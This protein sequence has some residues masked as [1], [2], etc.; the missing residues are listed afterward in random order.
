MDPVVA[1]PLFGTFLHAFGAIAAALCYTPQQGLRGWS[2]QTYWLT[3]ASICWLIAPIVGAFLTVPHLLDVLQAAPREAMLLTFALGVVYGVGGTAFGMAI[4]YV[5]YSLTYAIAIGISCFVGTFTG[6]LLSGTL[7]GIV[8]KAGSSWVLTG[9]FIGV[10]GTLA[11]G[12]AGRL[13]EIEIQRDQDNT[14]SFSLG[15]GLLLC[16]IAGLLSA[17]YGIAI[18]DAGKPIAEAAARLGAGHWQTN[19]VYIFVNSG[20]FLTTAVYTLFLGRRQK[21]LSEFTRLNALPSR[22]LLVNYLLAILTGCLWYGQFLFYGLGHVRMGEFKFSSWAIHMTMLILFSSLAGLVL[23]EWHGRRLRTKLALLTALSLLVTAVLTLTYGNLLG[24]RAAASTNPPEPIKAFCVDFNWG[25]GGPNG[26]AAP[27]VFNQADPAE[28]VA[29]YQD[30]GCNTIQTFCVSCC[31]YAWYRSDIAPVQPDMKGDFLKE[32]TELAHQ[33]DMKVMGYFCVGA[34]THWAQQH[35]DMSY[36]APS[37][38]HLPLTTQYLDYLCSCIEE[39]L[40]KT[41][42]DGFMID[43]VYNAPCPPHLQ[44]QDIQWMPCER[45]M[46]QE[47]FDQPFPGPDALDDEQVAEFCRRAVARA[48]D[49]IYKAAKTTR[50]DSIIWLTCF[51]LEHPQVIGSTMFK[52]VDW[53]MNE[54]TDPTVLKH[55]RDMVGPHTRIIQCVCGWGS[56][57]QA[58]KIMNDPANRDLGWYGFA[59]PDPDTT[60]PPMDSTDE[61]LAGNAQNIRAM[62]D[63]F[64]ASQND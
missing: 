2:W 55:V 9:V 6:P 44:L 20:A 42:I 29:W 27:G 64:H 62:R 63:A 11:C 7:A 36:G 40:Q 39:V 1:N 33:Q 28:H 47:L 17:V 13:K 61:R 24:E 8:D 50:P 22:V 45:Q 57:H 3:Q 46:Y 31:G 10:L 23:R 49:R 26:F 37:H 21:T 30:M 52:Q 19:P 53:L 18:N 15:K 4:R 35:P 59:Q 5:G 54:N 38:I 14:S 51:D 32:V 48:W 25:P 60:F 56:G 12:L 41:A 16:G 58:A 43:W 34:N